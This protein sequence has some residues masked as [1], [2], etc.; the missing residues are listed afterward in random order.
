MDRKCEW[1]GKRLGYRKFPRVLLLPPEYG[2]RKLYFHEPCLIRFKDAN[3]NLMRQ[4]EI[5]ALQKNY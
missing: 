1:C 4:K 2:N 3:P 5:D